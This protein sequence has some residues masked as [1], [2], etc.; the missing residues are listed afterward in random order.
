MISGM[1]RLGP[2]IVR[3]PHLEDWLGRFRSVPVR[4]L[5]APPGFGKTMALVGYLRH[6]ATNGFYCV[7]AAN[8]DGRADLGRDRH[9]R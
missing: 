2:S 5:I 8:R 3:R 4:F 1:P 6:S 7:L 9:A